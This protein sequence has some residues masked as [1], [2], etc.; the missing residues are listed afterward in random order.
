MT[1]IKRDRKV[2]DWYETPKTENDKK[3]DVIVSI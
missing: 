3:N 1:K 2:K